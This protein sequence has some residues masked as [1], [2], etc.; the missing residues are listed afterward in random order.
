MIH[1]TRTSIRLEV[2][3]QT[4][5]KIFKKGQLITGF[6]FLLPCFKKKLEKNDV[7]FKEK[8]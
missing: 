8:V 2:C 5:Y 1:T 7:I 3:F 4:P 6:F